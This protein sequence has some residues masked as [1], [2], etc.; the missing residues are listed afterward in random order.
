MIALDIVTNARA[1]IWVDSQG[2]LLIA[3]PGHPVPMPP[4]AYLA[5]QLL[6]T[7]DGKVIISPE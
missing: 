4:G 7:D 6:L 2:R 3:R 1:G 5:F